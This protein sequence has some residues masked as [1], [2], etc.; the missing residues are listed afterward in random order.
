MAFAR[1]SP[2]AQKDLEFLSSS[3]RTRSKLFSL[4]IAKIIA[5]SEHMPTVELEDIRNYFNMSIRM[6]T[7]K[8]L[9]AINEMLTL[10]ADLIE[11]YIYKFYCLRYSFINPPDTVACLDP[12]NVLM[13]FFGISNFI[14]KDDVVELNKDNLYLTDLYKK[15]FGIISELTR[16]EEV[17]IGR[18]D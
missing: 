11:T 5:D 3:G 7:I 16:A 6:S 2:N 1:L 9:S 18:E 14:S 12:E 17:L 15:V 4:V 8:K 13:D 10:D